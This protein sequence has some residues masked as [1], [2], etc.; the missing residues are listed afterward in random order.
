MA[1]PLILGLVMFFFLL[2][3][4]FSF[5]TCFT[6]DELLFLLL[7]RLCDRLNEIIL[8]HGMLTDGLCISFVNIAL[9]ASLGYTIN[10]TL[11]DGTKK[12]FNRGSQHI[13]LSSILVKNKRR[14]PVNGH[15]VS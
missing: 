1:L 7:F 4:C 9:V 11:N 2:T 10:N 13:N 5:Y 14:V 15:C 12:M 6:C 3:V 8:K